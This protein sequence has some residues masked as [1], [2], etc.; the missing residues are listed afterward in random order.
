MSLFLGSFAI[1]SSFILERGVTIAKSL[2]WLFGAVSLKKVRNRLL[3]AAGSGINPPIRMI[4]NTRPLGEEDQISLILK[5]MKKGWSSRTTL[6][7]VKAI[8]K[9]APELR[10]KLL[11]EETDLPWKVMVALAE[12]E[13][14]EHALKIIEF[15]ITRRLP[16][17]TAL[18]IIEDAKQ[19]IYPRYEVKYVDKFEETF[20]NFRVVNNII[21]K[22]SS[23]HYE[24]VRHNWDEI[25]PILDNIEKKIQAFRR[26]HS[27]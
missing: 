19:G 9:I 16:E 13:F 27:E 17:K 25:E 20:R 10:A 23:R 1:L 7:I 2:L 15:I 21:G 12:I 26:L 3:I 8:T 5:S 24:I 22:W 14:P 11:D 18:R 6:K 4:R